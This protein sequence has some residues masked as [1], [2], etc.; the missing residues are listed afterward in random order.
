MCF[1]KS[2]MHEVFSTEKQEQ[3]PAESSVDLE[4]Y[5]EVWRNISRDLDE[6]I[7]NANVDTRNSD[8]TR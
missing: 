3:K 4:K 1:D 7:N 2:H 8:L 5:M 6:I